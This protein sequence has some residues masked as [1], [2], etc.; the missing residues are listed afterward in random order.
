MKT[1]KCPFEDHARNLMK[2]D[3]VMIVLVLLIAF[4][5]ASF[6]IWKSF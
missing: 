1:E 3:I 4:N 6:F 2:F 5:I